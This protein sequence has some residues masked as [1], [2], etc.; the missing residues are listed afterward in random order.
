[1]LPILFFIGIFSS[2]ILAIFNYKKNLSTLYLSLF[3]F[4]ISTY[5]L[6]HYVLFYSNSVFLIAFFFSSNIGFITL[7]VGPMLFLYT[8][9]II[10]DKSN[11]KRTD[12]LHLIPI[13]IL[14]FGGFAQIFMP[15]AQ[16]LQFA[17]EYL[18]N[19][20][21]LP[22]EFNKHTNSSIPFL[23]M[24]I[25]RPVYI[26]TYLACSVGLFVKHLCLKK[27]SHVFYHQ[28]FMYFWL[29]M[30]FGLLMILIVSHTAILYNHYISNSTTISKFINIIQT[31]SLIGLIGLLFSP[32]LFPSILYGLPQIK[33]INKKQ[34]PD[35][36][37]LTNDKEKNSKQCHV[38][39]EHKERK[40]EEIYLKSIDNLIDMCM[41]DHQPYLNPD[42]N[43]ATLSVL[44]KVPIHH[45]IYY[46]K[47][48]KKQS[49]PEFRNYW[50]IQYA[51]KM[52]MEGKSKN[53]TL[54]AI[55]SLSGFSSRNT[56]LVSFKKH[57]NMTP[58]EFLRNIKN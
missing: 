14:F 4:S 9:S 19:N 33:S 21:I 25:F 57:E 44:I 52:I 5:S 38:K 42:F 24:F 12:I 6:I 43:M 58:Q 13:V 26:F 7:L 35:F 55:A 28:K 47:E 16:K 53:L 41:K 45:L 46:F 54:E 17:A 31:V 37:S 23:F 39:F 1:M 34:T 10:T 51:K 48:I 49:I 11:F 22:T 27:Q 40:L 36:D 20:K 3:F 2:M 15:W 8:R 56:F 32:F 50:R 29:S 30:L 18:N